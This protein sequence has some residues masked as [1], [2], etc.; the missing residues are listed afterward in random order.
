MHYHWGQT[1]AK[2][3]TLPLWTAH[4]KQKRQLRVVGW[5]NNRG[6]YREAY[7]VSSKSSEPKRFEQSW[8]KVYSRKT[9][10]LIPLLQSKHGFCQQNGPE[11]VQAQDWF[12]NKK[13]LV[14]PVS[15]N[16]LCC[17]SKI[18]EFLFS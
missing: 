13:I 17:F 6:A 1:A 4:I 2:K 9:T 3:G 18:L 7:I 14:V 10:K 11:Q 15:L 16:G 5:D 8:K 12:P